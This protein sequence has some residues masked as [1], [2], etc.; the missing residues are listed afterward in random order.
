MPRLDVDDREEALTRELAEWLPSPADEEVA[1]L[2][3]ATGATDVVI[4]RRQVF[5]GELRAIRSCDPPE[6]T[7]RLSVTHWPGTR[8]SR[9]HPRMPHWDEV[10]DARAELL[11]ANI[12]VVLFVPHP[13]LVGKKEA[14]TFHLYEYRGEPRATLPEHTPEDI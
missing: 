2:L 4:L 1:A 10:A 8:R 3:R 9:K 11:P 6:F 7:W 13:D 14:S 12:E 5:D